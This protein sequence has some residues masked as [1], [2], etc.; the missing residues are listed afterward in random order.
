MSRTI[1]PL[2]ALACALAPIAAQPLQQSLPSGFESGAGGGG[3]AYPFNSTSDQIWHW[4]YDSA[5]FNF[6]GPITITEC[7][8]RV[9]NNGTANPFDFPSVELTMATATTDYTVAG[10]PSQPGHDPV[11]ANN[12]A[13]DATVV[14]PAAPWVDPAPPTAT[15]MPMGMVVPFTYD[16]TTGNDFILQIVKCGTNASWGQS[17]FGTLVVPAGTNGGNRYGSTSSCTATSFSFSNNEFVPILLID[18]V[19]AGP[20][21]PEYQTNTLG[22]TFDIN[23]VA[24]TNSM[25]ATVNIAIGQSAQATFFSTN[26][27]QPWELLLGTAP[28]IPLSGGAFVTADSQV[29]NVDL[30][31]PTL[32]YLWSLFQSP[33][34]ATAVVPFSVPSAASLSAQM[35]VVD[36]AMLVGVSISQPTALVVQ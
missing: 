31:D 22:A 25:P 36:P 2:I 13:A 16:P 18:Y 8:V 17:I 33:G 12:L 27:G 19:P 3:S 14:R 29:I 10:T 11:F 26:F 4:H 21:G 23:Q 7:Y 24:G 5:Q 1:L 32:V 30:G 9:L 28:L 34:F 35:L 6:V 20:A 15:W